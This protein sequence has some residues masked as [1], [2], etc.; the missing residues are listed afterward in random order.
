[1]S[2]ATGKAQRWGR[3]AVVC[4]AALGV[5]LGVYVGAYLYCRDVNAGSGWIHFEYGGVS[6]VYPASVEAAGDIENLLVVFG[7]GIEMHTS[8]RGYV[9]FELG[10]YQ[11][12][13]Q[14]HLPRLFGP[15]ERLELKMKGYEPVEVRAYQQWRASQ[16]DPI[17]L[18]DEP[19]GDIGDEILDLIE[20]LEP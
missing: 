5:L 7:H 1:M 3:R 15:L 11:H 19:A 4:G 17:D 9:Y 10:R 2:R 6:R 13:H 12:W 20:G 8:G 14:L 16:H 18:L